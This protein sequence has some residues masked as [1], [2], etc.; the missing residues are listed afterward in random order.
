MLEDCHAV[1]EVYWKLICCD[2]LEDREIKVTI[3]HVIHYG[4][5]DSISVHTDQNLAWKSKMH[6]QNSQTMEF[7]MQILQRLSFT[8]ENRC[9]PSAL[10][11]VLIDPSGFKIY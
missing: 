6:R 8:I 1:S 5:Q 11:R 10:P 9:I 4:S 2:P 3:L 7:C